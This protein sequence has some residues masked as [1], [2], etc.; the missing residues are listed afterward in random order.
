MD[1]CS[2]LQIRAFQHTR[3]RDSI[4]SARFSLSTDAKP[5]KQRYDI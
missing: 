3:Y 2:L 1:I 4:Y 5:D